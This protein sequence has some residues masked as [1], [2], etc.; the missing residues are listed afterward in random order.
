MATSINILYISYDGMTDPLGQSQVLP[1]ICGL[2]Q[3]GYTY[4]LISCEKVDRYEKTRAVIEKICQ[5]NNIDWQPV[6]YHKSPPILSTIWDLW[7]MKKI[8][9]RLHEIKEFKLIHCRG[10]L[11][12]L[13]GLAMKRKFKTKFLFDMRGL[14]A[15]EKVDAGAWRLSNPVFKFVYNFF[16]RKEKDFFL[17]ADWSVSLTHAGKR[18]IQSWGYMKGREDNISVIP[19]CADIYLFDYTKIDIEKKKAW[20]E[21]LTISETDFILSY[22]GSIGT[23]Y[24]L[25]EMLDFFVEFKKEFPAARFLFITHDEHER[26]ELA[27]KKRG[28]WNDIII[29]PGQRAE[30]SSLLS[31]SSL[32]IFFIRATYSKLSSSP[33]KQGEIMAM[34]IPIICN[35]GVGDTDTIVS[36]YGSGLV[37]HDFNTSTYQSIIHHVKQ[38]KFDATKIR[39]GAIDYFSLEKGVNKY[40]EIYSRLI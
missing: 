3:Q 31:L 9:Y 30:V 38:S 8:A 36:D 26:I 23:W 25:D 14:W 39:K 1:Y 11:S 18:E 29:Q 6:I 40:L 13:F 7:Q 16:K 34:G 32:S 15:D 19:C 21:K 37:V 17:E 22:L 2:T 4:T 24:M 5:E 33:T 28:V 27:A 35:S 10:Y 20:Q 12:A